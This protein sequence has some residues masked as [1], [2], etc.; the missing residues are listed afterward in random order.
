MKEPTRP[1]A[2]TK[3]PKIRAPGKAASRAAFETGAS[4]RDDAE[5]AKWFAR[6]E[7]AARAGDDNGRQDQAAHPRIRARIGGPVGNAEGAL[8]HEFT[9]LEAAETGDFSK[10]T[11]YPSE[12]KRAQALHRKYQRDEQAVASKS[13]P[14]FSWK[15]ERLLLIQQTA[16]F[17]RA[18]Q[19]REGSS[20][21]PSTPQQEGRTAGDNH[22][23]KDLRHEKNVTGAR[24]ETTQ[25]QPKQ[26][27]SHERTKFLAYAK[28]HQWD[29]DSD[30]RPSDHI[31]KNFAK[32]LKLGLA[33]TDIIAAQE[34][35]AQAYSTEISRNPDRRIEELVVRPHSLPPGAKRAL[36][37]SL[38]SELT[39]QE[40]ERKRA[41]ER[42]K[43]QRQ[44][45]KKKPKSLAQ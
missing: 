8:V 16:A 6:I 33:R 7:K 25:R 22:A 13:K 19:S 26:L 43:K 30:V 45:L 11:K 31:K 44:R 1:N 18:L 9:I 10:L 29:S 2:K 41:M 35:L 17:I 32:W 38:V 42:D 37:T 24:A 12:L 23:A 36:S 3:A 21:N 4:E 28:A 39:P 15:E 34:N 27:S 40:L 5:L 20:Y 14:R